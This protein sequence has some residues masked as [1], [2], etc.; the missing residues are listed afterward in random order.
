MSGGAIDTKP[1]EDLYNISHQSYQSPV[2]SHQSP[3]GEQRTV[4]NQ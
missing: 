1:Q 4:I 3:V 2:T